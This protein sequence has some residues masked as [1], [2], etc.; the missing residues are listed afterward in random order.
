M[1]RRNTFTVGLIY[2][3]CKLN[4]FYFDMTAKLEIIYLSLEIYNL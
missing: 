4:R 3:E 1:D 2:M